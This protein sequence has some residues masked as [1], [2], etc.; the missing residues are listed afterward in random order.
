MSKYAWSCFNI[1]V[2]GTS[3]DIYLASGIA[4]NGW[5]IDWNNALHVWIYNPDETAVDNSWN[6]SGDHVT[7]FAA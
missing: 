6:S 2:V 5:G 7:N 3:C 1:R 4:N